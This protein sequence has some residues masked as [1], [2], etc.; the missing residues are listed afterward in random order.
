MGRGNKHAKAAAPA[1]PPPPSFDDPIEDQLVKDGGFKASFHSTY[2]DITERTVDRETAYAECGTP[3][4]DLVAHAIKF[5]CAIVLLAVQTFTVHRD[6]WPPKTM[7]VVRAP[8]RRSHTLPAH[9]R[10]ALTGPAP[11][12]RSATRSSSC[13]SPSARTSA[14][15]GRT[16]R[17]PPSS[18]RRCASSAARSR[19]TRRCAARCSARGGAWHMPPNHRRS[20]PC[21]VSLSPPPSHPPCARPVPTR[22]S[23][24]TP[25]SAAPRPLGFSRPFPAAAPSQSSGRASSLFAVLRLTFAPLHPLLDDPTST[26]PHRTRCI[27]SETGRL[28]P[29]LSPPRPHLQLASQSTQKPLKPTLS[30]P[31]PLVSAPRVRSAACPR[32]GS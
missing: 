1:E 11:P 20:R 4:A 12:R 14:A 24:S 16:A 5:A 17:S 26:P 6:M 31:E 25:S 32:G 9:L 22:S 30:I 18:G 21:V 3:Y 7:A 15:T 2:T 19:S 27:P 10:R 23:R 8:L 13:S 28:K 29:L